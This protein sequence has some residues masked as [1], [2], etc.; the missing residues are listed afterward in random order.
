MAE[1]TEDQKV[2]VVQ[3]LARFKPPAEIVRIM[4]E[5]HAL[6]CS[7]QQIVAYDPTRSAFRNGDR[8]AELF[9]ITREAFIKNVEDVPLAHSGYRLQV[10][11]SVL[12][13][14]LK[15]KKL[16]AAVKVVE[17]AAKEVGGL[18]SAIDKAKPA[19]TKDAEPELTQRERE[20]KLGGLID[21]ALAE[22]RAKATAPGTEARQ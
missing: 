11:Q 4:K 21:G 1:L 22:M 2:E 16:D 10:L 15:H 19:D 20:Q 9:K 7:I 6:D 8:F 17:Q 13:S 12:E 14:H 5:E 18:Y 3:H